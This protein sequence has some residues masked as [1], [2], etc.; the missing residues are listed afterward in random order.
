MDDGWQKMR[1]EAER[2]EAEAFARRNDPREQAASA[3]LR[4]LSQLVRA[5]QEGRI[6]YR[7]LWNADK[8]V[9]MA[10]AAGF[11]CED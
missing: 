7:H 4:A 2:A 9:E 11:T 3:M 8:A 1:E 5:V 6:Q 10:R